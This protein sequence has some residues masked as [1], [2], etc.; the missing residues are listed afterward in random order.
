MIRA[1]LLA[2]GDLGRRSFRLVVW[3][4]LALT[5]VLLASLGVA[6]HYGL[7][8]LPLFKAAWLNTTINIVGDLGI[9]VAS[10]VLAAPVASLFIGLFLEGVAEKVE[11]VHYPDDAPGRSLGLLPTLTTAL[12]FLLALL[13]V[14]LV[15]LPLYL[16]PGANAVVYLAANG[17]LLGREYFELVALRRLDARA[18][19]AMRR[20]FRWRLFVGGILI[21]ALLSIPVI[22]WLMPMVA[23]AFMV[24]EFE[25]IRQRT[26]RA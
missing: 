21:T 8:A 20:R 7:S 5:L 14:N 22:N 2:L 9:V 15:A 16:I 3:Q 17:Y 24:H 18:A 4:A 25:G 12:A 19:A 11:R 13:L 26:A 6:A 10:V 1:V 23:T